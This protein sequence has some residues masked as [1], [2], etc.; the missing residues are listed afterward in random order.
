MGKELHVECCARSPTEKLHPGIYGSALYVALVVR[1]GCHS[2]KPRQSIVGA[3]LSCWQGYLVYLLLG[4]R[5]GNEG[6]VVIRQASFRWLERAGLFEEC[7]Q[8]RKK[9]VTEAVQGKGLLLVTFETCAETVAQLCTLRCELG[10]A[11]RF[12]T[13]LHLQPC[14]FTVTACNHL[15]ASTTKN[16]SFPS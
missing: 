9:K 3:L 15:R 6:V 2:K 11:S 4:Q 5:V 13:G 7:E 16:A 14:S 1:N 8:K 12:S 10:V